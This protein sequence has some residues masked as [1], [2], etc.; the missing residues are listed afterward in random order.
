MELKIQRKNP[1]S[2]VKALGRG[3]KWNRAL[4][5]AW[6]HAGPYSSKAHGHGLYLPFEFSL[7]EV[8]NVFFFS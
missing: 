5:L 7:R 3:V 2:A 4:H 8:R 1:G 6:S